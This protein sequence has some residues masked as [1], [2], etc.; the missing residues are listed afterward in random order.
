M[1]SFLKKKR[2]M[3]IIERG[4][5]EQENENKKDAILSGTMWTV[6]NSAQKSI[7]EAA[8]KFAKPYKYDRTVLDDSVAKRNIKRNAFR[9]GNKVRDPYTNDT[10]TLTKQEARMK[11]GDNWTKHLAEADHKIPLEQRYEQTK[12]NPWLSNDN[13]RASSNST[14]NLENVSRKFNNAK[15]SKSN[16]EFVTDNEYLE[17]TGVRLTEQGKRA[18]I[19]SE[20]NAQRAL[21]RKDFKDTVS[22]MVETG[23]NAGMAAAGDAAVA[24]ATMSTIMNIAAVISG[25]KTAEDAIADTAIDT[26]RAAATGYAMGNGLTTISHS[27]SGSKSKFLQALSKSNV[28]ANVISAVMLTGDVLIRF[29][30][31]EITTQECLIELGE[32]G[33]SAATTGYSYAVGQ[34][35]IPVPIVGGAVGALV[36]T[37]LTSG[38]YNQLIYSLKMKELEHQERL[39]IIEE[40]RKV[41]H[42]AQVFRE[43]LERYLSEYFEDYQNCF[44]EALSIIDFAFQTGDADGMI[45]GANQITRKLRGNVNY[46]TTAE[47]KEFLLDGTV[48]VL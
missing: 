3:E 29:E 38:Y 23:H 35:L 32:R 40:S 5:E 28:P 15:R 34:A 31:G 48:D 22:N 21:K 43:K 9:S 39:R 47:F 14:D 46:N 12:N 7:N 17:K 26:G 36:G 4:E 24:G 25:E 42:E 20:K 8:Q 6:R 11:Y 37:L 1:F 18:A 41:A 16:R 33:L 44:D 45:A 2:E 27:L 10:L 13:I 30:K 19:E